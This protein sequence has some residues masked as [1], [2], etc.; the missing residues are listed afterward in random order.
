MKIKILEKP[1]VR[2]ALFLLLAFSVRFF[3]ATIY[4]PV[5]GE[6]GIADQ[7]NYLEMNYQTIDGGYLNTLKLII[8]REKLTRLYVRTVN[9]I[10]TPVMAVGR[11]F[12]LSDL[13]GTIAGGSLIGALSIIPLWHISEHLKINPM[14]TS[15]IYVFSPLDLGDVLTWGGYSTLFGV[16]SVNVYIWLILVK[17]HWASG[18]VLLPVILT[19]RTSIIYI[20]I[21]ITVLAVLLLA[22]KRKIEPW[23]V[24]SIL[25]VYSVLLWEHGDVIINYLPG[26]GYVPGKTGLETH[27]PGAQAP[28]AVSMVEF[29][30]YLLIIGLFSS[31]LALTGLKPFLIRNKHSMIV[32]SWV[33]LPHLLVFTPIFNDPYYNFRLLAFAAGSM[34][35]LISYAFEKWSEK[36]DI[37]K[38]TLR[39]LLLFMIAEAVTRSILAFSLYGIK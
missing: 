32:L 17:R 37:W 14:I 6:R 21:F 4:T 39:L 31:I 22:S 29:Q 28:P 34:C 26:K 2:I 5:G 38:V 7:L 3:L 11:L 24:V 12:G 25:I 10:L 18:L 15:L 23:L 13:T 20:T 19:H 30:V 1:A 33:I 8:A 16:L 9:L 27:V 36:S 35:L